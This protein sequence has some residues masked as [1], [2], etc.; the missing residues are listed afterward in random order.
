[1]TPPH[2]RS[3]RETLA[4]LGAAALVGCVPGSSSDSTSTD[5]TTDASADTGDSGTTASCAPRTSS[6]TAGPFYP[7]EPVARMDITEGISGVA[8]ELDLTCVDVDTCMPLVGAEVDLWGANADGDYSGY[9][10]F[11]TVGEDWMRGQQITGADG[12]ARFTAIVPGSYP[13][14]AV[15]LHV[16]V[17]PVGG[18][19]LTTQVYFPDATVASVLGEAAYAA[20]AAQTTND[21]DGIYAGDTLVPLEGSLA[22]GYSGAITLKV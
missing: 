14:R 19:E 11:D 9:A 13:G 1:M 21:R 16:K 22:E 10:D 4:A 2:D 3:R 17:R 20:S 18:G 7:G 15:H 12:V 5:A 6:Q 8:L